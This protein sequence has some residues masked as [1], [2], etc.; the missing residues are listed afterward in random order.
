[1]SLLSKSTI[2]RHFNRAA[3]QYAEA[4]FLQN[5]VLQRVATRFDVMKIDPK[6]VLDFGARVGASRPLLQSRFP[7]TTI[8]AYECSEG[9]LQQVPRRWYQRALPNVCGD[10][11]QLPFANH[12][13]DV[14]FSNLTLHWVNDLPHLLREFYRVLIPGGLL[15]FTMVGPDTLKELRAAFAAHSR[16]VHLHRFIDMHD[17][18]DELMKAHFQNPVMDMEYLQMRYDTVLHLLQD[19]KATGVTNARL[20]R[21][22]GLMGK[23]RWNAMLQEYADRFSSL[24][25]GVTATVEIIYGHAWMPSALEV[26]GEVRV[27][28][29]SLFKR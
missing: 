20:D 18:G 11:E 8:I 15:L 16:D 21:A 5:E 1:M 26:E 10:Y 23:T 19:L 4:A 24:E 12:S 7:K 3:Q 28:V 14:I 25:A 6:H 9:L 27:P 29:S 2:R 13:F 17:V 22:R